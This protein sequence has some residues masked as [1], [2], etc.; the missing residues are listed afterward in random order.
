MKKEEENQRAYIVWV[1]EDQKILSFQRLDGYQEKSF[2][3]HDE[4]FAYVVSLCESG[5]R[6]Q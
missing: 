4:K 6:I 3:S 5:Y 1:S 2:P